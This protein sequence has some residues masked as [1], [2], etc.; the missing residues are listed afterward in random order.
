MKIIARHGNCQVFAFEIPTGLTLVTAQYL[1]I[2][3][4][5]STLSLH[6]YNVS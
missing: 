1:K 3:C 2:D 6:I 4:K 5:F